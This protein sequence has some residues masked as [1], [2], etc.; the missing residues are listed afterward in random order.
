MDRRGLH[1]E[2]DSEEHDSVD[3]KQGVLDRRDR[4]NKN[5]SAEHFWGGDALGQFSFSASKTSL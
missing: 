1:N 3:S 5:D 4:C 2:T